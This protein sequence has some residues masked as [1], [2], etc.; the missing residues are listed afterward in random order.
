MNDFVRGVA[1]FTLLVFVGCNANGQ[2]DVA[3]GQV[4]SSKVFAS[5][6]DFAVGPPQPGNPNIDQR[7]MVFNALMNS[8]IWAEAGK[9]DL[10]AHRPIVEEKLRRLEIRDLAYLYSSE[11]VER[12]FKHTEEELFAWYEKHPELFVVNGKRLSFAV[13]RDSVAF[14][15]AS[16]ERKDA[17]KKY[18]QT[19]VNEFKDPDTAVVGLL[20]SSDSIK[21]VQAMEQIKKG[22]AF[23]EVAGKLLQDSSLLQVKGRIPPVVEGRFP[24]ELNGIPEYQTLLF[25]ANKKLALR[26]FSKVYSSEDM[27]DFKAKT[28]QA[29][30]VFRYGKAGAPV[31]EKSQIQASA[32]YLQ[33][34]RASASKDAR[35][36]LVKVLRVV[37]MPLPPIDLAKM[38]QNGPKM[39]T[40]VTY[41]LLHWEATDSLSL[42]KALVKVKSEADF[43]KEATARSTNL[44]TRS[45]G[46]ELGLVKVAHCLPAG[47]GMLPE[48]FQELDGRT[49]GFKSSVLKSPDSEKWNAFWVL[50]VVPPQEKPLDRVKVALTA[51][52]QERGMVVADTGFVLTEIDGKPVLRE[53]DLIALSKEVPSEQRQSIT[54]DR[55]YDLMEDWSIYA[56]EARKL[57]LEKT[58]AAIALHTLREVDQW[59]DL[60]KDS[61]VHKTLGYSDA[62]LRKAFKSNPKGMFTG[63]EF[64]R[65]RY[66]VARWLEFPDFVYQREFLAHPERYPGMKTWKDAKV[67][68][69]KEIR[70][71]EVQGADE[72]MANKQ[73]KRF[74]AQVLD[75][76]YAKKIHYEPKAI[77]A[78][79][80]ALYEERE[81]GEARMLLQRVRDL[82]GLDSLAYQATVLVAQSFNEEENY[83]MAL[84]EYSV[85]YGL[86]PNRP[87]AYKN[88][89]MKGFILSENLKQDS[90]ALPVFKELL[91]RFP[92]C[93][94]A[95][96]AEWM[97]R[98]IQSG[99]ALAPAL[100]DRISEEEAPATP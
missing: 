9:A 85:A 83:S 59:A 47:I 60:F 62:E 40:A 86:W 96:D 23:D 72:R 27:N 67:A 48:L 8:R 34:W 37:R 22:K 70:E 18:F 78:A 36:S 88:L 33:K 51:R 87:D 68:I 63:M 100:L 74:H 38:Y 98:N 7:L 80:K 31:W 69:F 26:Q 6:V 84:S 21:L 41:R 56:V 54:R 65:A 99:G 13:A 94:L 53:S 39:M 76:N 79:G 45:K 15:M 57:G 4:G 46:G 82:L 20:A 93:E 71:L 12:N 91:K 64:E 42:A 95:D 61:V 50:G 44:Q 28:Y 90:L 49:V 29:L 32:V 24:V 55:L 19:N 92:K 1:A 75:S 97:V 14:R 17:I 3:L 43:R 58:K 10:Q 11:Y 81:L 35:D 66:L 25:D 89:F 52:A 30:Y 77:L 73:I 5:E 16:A 2:S